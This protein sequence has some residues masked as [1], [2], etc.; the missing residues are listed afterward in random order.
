MKYI[1]WKV[2]LHCAHEEKQRNTLQ[3]FPRKGKFK[4][5]AWGRLFNSNNNNS[6]T[7]LKYLV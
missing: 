1:Y 3:D 5:E 7:L 2:R 6:K 4:K